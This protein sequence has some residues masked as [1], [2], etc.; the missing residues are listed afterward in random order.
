MPDVTCSHCGNEIPVDQAREADGRY[1]C[2]QWCYE[3]YYAD[4]C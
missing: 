3:D 1:F 4:A 2:N